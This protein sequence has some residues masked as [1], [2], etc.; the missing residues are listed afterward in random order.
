MGHLTSP[1]GLRK[2]H[3]SMK[4]SAM[5]VR[6]NPENF[7]PLLFE[8][9]HLVRQIV[10]DQEI[11]FVG[12]DICRTLG[13]SNPRSSLALLDEDERGVY[14]MDTLGGQQDMTIVSEAGVYRLV[15]RSRKPVAERFKR[16]LAHE[17]IPAIR[18]TGSYG[19]K[20]ESADQ[21][22]EMQDES[23]NVKLRMVTEG[24]QT[25]GTQAAAQLWFRLN[26]PIVPAMLH[27]PRQL[28]L[29]DYGA[30]KSVEGGDA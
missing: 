30:I 5:N 18:Q 12:A 14:T 7:N 19:A 20:S 2:L 8:E 11:W 15:F 10:K 23:E 16:W 6:T 21:F 27:D 28:N 17:V 9:Q 1:N 4:V 25:F 22:S 29:M 13:I 24:R 26:L 3:F